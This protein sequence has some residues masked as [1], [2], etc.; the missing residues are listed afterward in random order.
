MTYSMIYSVLKEKQN[1]TAATTTY[2][3]MKKKLSSQASVACSYNPSYS[4]GRRF[5]VQSQHRQI[6]HE[7][8]PQKYLIQKRAGGMA[9]VIRVPA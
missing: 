8:L 1:Q 6:V 7:T 9:Q 4:E 3:P 2:L 5:E